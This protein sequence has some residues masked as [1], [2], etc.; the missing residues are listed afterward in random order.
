MKTKK[1]APSEVHIAP[2][3]NIDRV[4]AFSQLADVLRAEE[5]LPTIA[6]H[7]LDIW[8]EIAVGNPKDGAA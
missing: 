1:N 6:C 2:D 5:P 7:T 8:H 3:P 4:K